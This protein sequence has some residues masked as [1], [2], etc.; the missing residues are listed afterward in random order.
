MRPLFP[1]GIFIIGGIICDPNKVPSL[2][3]LQSAIIK[4]GA[5]SRN[6]NNGV[7]RPVGRPSFQLSRSLARSLSWKHFLFSRQ[8]SDLSVS[9]VDFGLEPSDL[10]HH[11]G[12]SALDFGLEPS[13][14]SEVL[15]MLRTT[16]PPM[17]YFFNPRSRHVRSAGGCLLGLG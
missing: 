5:Y 4:S 13:D 7:R 8:P 14:L 3:G 17:T 10:S 15:V 9:A 2:P 12:I 6:I 16:R 1:A 11:R